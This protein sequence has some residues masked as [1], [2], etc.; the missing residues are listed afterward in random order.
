MSVSK[1]GRLM[2]GDW[3]LLFNDLGLRT[4]A[5]QIGDW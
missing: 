4:D 5:A 2:I 3:R 1:F